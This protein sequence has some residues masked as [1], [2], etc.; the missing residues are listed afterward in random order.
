MYPVELLMHGTL[1]PDVRVS[2]NLE[3]CFR[4][5]G[6]HFDKIQYEHVFQGEVATDPCVLVLIS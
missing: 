4:L 5:F 6:E 2:S 1:L 3:R